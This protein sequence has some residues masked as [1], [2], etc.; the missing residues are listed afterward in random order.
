MHLNEVNSA[1]PTL[2][3]LVDRFATPSWVPLSSV[4]SAGDI[5]IVAGA[6]ILLWRSCGAHLPHRGGQQP[7][8]R[9]LAGGPS[10]TP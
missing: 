6:G 1:H 8:D 4:F 3:W 2:P 10:G 9:G 5:L 7:V